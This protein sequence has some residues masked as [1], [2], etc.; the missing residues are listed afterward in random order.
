[1]KLSRG[2]KIKVG[3]GV[4]LIALVL[5]FAVFG[6]WPLRVLSGAPFG[7]RVTAG[8]WRTLQDKEF[9]ADEVRSLDVDMAVGLAEIVPASGDAVRVVERV[10][11]AADEAEASEVALVDGVLAVTSPEGEGEPSVSV[12]GIELPDSSH[13][14]DRQLTIELPEALAASL[15]E[16]KGDAGVAALN[17]EGVSCRSLDLT[18]G[19]GD[20]VFDGAVAE[21][22]ACD[23]ATGDVRVTTG[24]VPASMSFDVGV[25]AAVLALPEDAGFT[26]EVKAGVGGFTTDFS[27][28]RSDDGGF[29]GMVGDSA[30]YRCGDGSAR[31]VVNA[32]VGGVHVIKR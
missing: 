29:G 19:V 10:K 7:L 3:I 9:T 30:T 12:F 14:E 21:E 18:I 5:V 15:D 22:L 16:V 26:A 23:V 13:P 8:E 31:M 4:G 2:S 6:A 28:E 32:G 17:I 1:M 27:V 11:T 20:V 25:G 24:A